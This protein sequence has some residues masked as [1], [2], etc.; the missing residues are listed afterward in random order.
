VNLGDLKT[1]GIDFKATGAV[2]SAFDAFIP[3]NTSLLIHGSNLKTLIDNVISAQ[4]MSN[5][6]VDKEMA[7]G[8]ATLKAQLGLDVD[9][10]VLDWMTGDFA[11]F[12]SIDANSFIDLLLKSIESSQPPAMTQFPVGFGVV[13]KATDPAKAKAFA[14]NL[15]KLAGLAAAQ[16]PQTKVTQDRIGDVPVTVVSMSMPM[17][18]GSNVPLN[19]VIGANDNVFVLATRKEAEVIFKGISGLS[20]TADYS[21]ASKYLLKNPSS[22]FYLNQDGFTGFAILEFALFGPAIGNVFENIVSSL[23]TPNAP[24][25]T[26]EEIQREK[27][28]QIDAEKQQIA[29]FKG[30]ASIFESSTISSTT[31]DQGDS[32]IRL[33]ITLAQ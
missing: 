8:K 16:N 4:R 27:Q 28:A 7:Q 23:E 14:A 12:A 29:L 30:I 20:G 31:T 10:D 22:V 18:P 21:Q 6:N 11:F 19:L 26:P 13:V 25:K 32:V 5:P 17:S 15:G 2:D 24:T 3:A 33:V 1:L 9:K